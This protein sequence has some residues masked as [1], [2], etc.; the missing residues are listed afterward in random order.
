MRVFIFYF[1]LTAAP[2][3]AWAAD[4]WGFFGHKKINELAVYTLPEEVFGFYKY[5][6][7]YLVTHAVDPDKRRY[8]LKGEAE[9][10]FLDVDRY[11]DTQDS[12]A[13]CALPMRWDEAVLIYSEDSLRKHGIAPWNL[14]FVYKRLVK[15]F[16]EANI[17]RVLQLSAE[18]GHYVGDIHVPLHTTS[19][20]NGQQTNQRGIHGFWESRVPEIKFTEYS[21]WMPRA[22]YVEDPMNFIWERLKESYAAV[23]SVLRFEREL[24][25]SFPSDNKYTYESRNGVEIRTYSQDFST[26]YT[27][28]LGNQ[29]ERRMQRAV[30]ALGCLWYSAWIESGQPSLSKWLITLPPSEEQLPMEI[31]PVREHE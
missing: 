2:C 23:D 15:A 11:Y 9:C 31:L 8:G 5:H 26:A 18:L 13:W 1:M 21:F 29:V 10:H 19:N 4:D 20:Y 7:N 17:Q 14:Y 22:R 27:T 3:S 6:M 16:Q 30:Y 12:N 24:T 25:A 28:M